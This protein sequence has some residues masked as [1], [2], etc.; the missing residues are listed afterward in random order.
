M[1]QPNNTTTK[2]TITM[3]E[4][5]VDYLFKKLWD[6]PKDKLTWYAILKEAKRIQKQ[7]IVDACYEGM[8]AQGFD[9]NK[10]RCEQYYN[11]KYE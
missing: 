8:Q 4:T 7:Q 2:P 1:S 5:A 3:T 11:S 6:T 10:G 9:P